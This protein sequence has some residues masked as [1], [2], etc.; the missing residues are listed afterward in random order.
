MIDYY[1]VFSVWNG[2]DDVTITVYR[3]SKEFASFDEASAWAHKQLPRVASYT[4]DHHRDLA[5]EVDDPNMI[6]VT[7]QPFSK[8]KE[9][10]VKSASDIETFVG[11]DDEEDEDEEEEDDGDSKDG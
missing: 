7:I 1:I 11:T 5:S 4:R 2:L 10:L 9:T 6:E 3:C 8:W